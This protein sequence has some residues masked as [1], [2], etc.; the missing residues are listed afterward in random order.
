METHADTLPLSFQE[1]EMIHT[2]GR[3]GHIHQAMNDRLVKRQEYFTRH[4]EDLPE[5]R[6]WK[7]PTNPT[8]EN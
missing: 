5:I 3:A 4:G 2:Q 6:D 8:V 1:L 7:W